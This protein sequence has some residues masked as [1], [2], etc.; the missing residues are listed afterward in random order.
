MSIRRSNVRTPV[1]P[2]CSSPLVSDSGVEKICSSLPRLKKLIL[3]SSYLLT[4]KSLEHMLQLQQL[5]T[6]DIYGNDN[7]SLLATYLFLKAAG[8]RMKNFN[9]SEASGIIPRLFVDSAPRT[10]IWN[11]DSIEDEDIEG[12]IQVLGE[13][14]CKTLEEVD[15]SLT[16]ISAIGLD[17]I[18]RNFVNLKKISVRR[19]DCI[20]EREIESF[21]SKL[22]NCEVISDFN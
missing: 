14:R 18:A 10:F 17:L 2:Y 11:F 15:F 21:E 19:C 22:P 4:N 7:I 20:T 5:E 3:G 16:R 8:T 1:P 12:L 13:D 6:L 9:G